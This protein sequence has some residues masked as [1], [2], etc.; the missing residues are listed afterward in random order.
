MKYCSGSSVLIGF[1]SLRGRFRTSRH[2]RRTDTNW[3]WLPESSKRTGGM[4]QWSTVAALKN[5]SNTPKTACQGHDS[6][7]LLRLS[8]VVPRRHP[9]TNRAS[10]LRAECARVE[11]HSD[12]FHR[13]VRRQA[14]AHESRPVPKHDITAARGLRHPPLHGPRCLSD[15]QHG[16]PMVS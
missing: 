11:H 6:T 13:L 5:A 7:P 2:Q 3:I 15:T 14:E 4:S 8:N 1:L 12:V 10:P 9:H 16:N